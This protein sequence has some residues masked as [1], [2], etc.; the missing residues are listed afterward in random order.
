MVE[1]HRGVVYPAEF[2]G[3]YEDWSPKR[4]I[5]KCTVHPASPCCPTYFSITRKAEESTFSP[6]KGRTVPSKSDDRL[7]LACCI[8]VCVCV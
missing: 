6:D 7:S 3:P 2:P 4:R 1:H 8:G 5:V